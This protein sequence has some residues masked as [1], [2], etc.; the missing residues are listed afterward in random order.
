MDKMWLFYCGFNQLPICQKTNCVNH[1][2]PLYYIIHKYVKIIMVKIGLLLLK[3]FKLG[4]FIISNNYQTMKL[5]K[6]EFQFI[7]G[8]NKDKGDSSSNR[9]DIGKSSITQ[10][11]HFKVIW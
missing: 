4:I 2:T 10:V 1:H 9:S 3:K 8:F 6:K 5:Y 11:I 7:I